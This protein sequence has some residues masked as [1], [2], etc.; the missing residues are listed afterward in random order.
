[1]RICPITRIHKWVLIL[2]GERERR[3]HYYRQLILNIYC[4]KIIEE[5]D[6]SEDEPISDL[7]KILILRVIQ[8]FLWNVN[9]WKKES[10]QRFIFKSPISEIAW[11]IIPKI[12]IGYSMKWRQRNHLSSNWYVI[13]MRGRNEMLHCFWFHNNV[14]DI[15]ETKKKM[16]E[17]YK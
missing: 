3:W 1:M 12:L 8:K 14:L 7:Q 6:D 13:L 5:L 11:E 2:T 4:D 15:I 10:L 16:F 9:F 17:V